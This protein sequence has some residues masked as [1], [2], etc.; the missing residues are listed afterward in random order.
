MFW[1]WILKKIAVTPTTNR[2]EAPAEYLTPQSATE[3]LSTPRRQKLLEQIW[4]R[5][6]LSRK[7][8]ADLYQC[9]IERYAELV[10]QLP[11]SHNHHHAYPGGM[12]DHGLE[13]MVYALKL[14]QSHLL[15][16]GATTEAQAAQTEAWTIVIAYAALLHDIGKIVVD[17][18]VQMSNGC[19]WHPWNGPLNRPYRFR[20]VKERQYKLHGAAAGLLCT[21]I[22][23]H[24]ILDWLSSYPEPW[25]ALL[26]FLA[27]QY[28][29]AGTLGVLVI[30][31][32][33][34]SVAQE[35]GGNP[36]K[37]LAAPK[38]SLQRQLIEGLRYLAF[39]QLKLNQSR[40]S[41]GWLTEDAL[42]LVCK[43]VADKLRAHLLSQGTEGIP[44]SNDTLF[45]LL[46]DNAIIQVNT[47]GK[48][49]WNATIQSGKWRRTLTFLKVAPALIWESAERPPAFS[50]SVTV[51]V[52]T[53]KR[54]EGENTPAAQEDL[55]LET[56]PHY[57]TDVPEHEL[58]RPQQWMGMPD[59][60]PEH[61]SD[62]S[63]VPTHN[64]IEAP[65]RIDPGFGPV[66]SFFEQ[67]PSHT[68]AH[69]PQ[70]NVSAEE[71]GQAFMKWLRQGILTNKIA[72]N[73]ATAKVHS[74]AGT[75]FLISPGIFKRYT[76]EHPETARLAKLQGTSDWRWLQ[77]CF[78]KLGVH[79]NSEDGLSIRTCEIQ[80]PRKTRDIKGYLLKDPL[81]I[82]TERPYD[83]PYLRVKE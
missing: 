60:H 64:E 80:G 47:E 53:G 31:A 68:Q 24:S 35:L 21:Q 65:P 50:G 12:L 77:R 54:E 70:P 67:Q 36:T 56:P 76:D 2:G 19:L 11:A 1:H 52:S 71:L 62:L 29:H 59:D 82:F 6:S 13:S 43:T 17:V 41:D 33:Q 40:A 46:Q 75:A 79:H 63:A 49:I 30:Q 74:V 55:A 23:P 83:N 16:I 14:R 8:F 73:D 18:K 10:Q 39:E 5:T 3:L 32:D 28:E 42:W 7:Q 48:A 27:G 45:N 15:P 4:Q 78:E 81:L 57:V 26:F 51:Q 25:N 34:A 72:I 44:S 58:Y 38:S 37:A 69:P 61:D 20:Y 22:V 9:P 66:P